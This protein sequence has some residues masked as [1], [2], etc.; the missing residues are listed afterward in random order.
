MN[1]EI[2]AVGTEI[3]LGQ[4]VNT[5]AQIISQ[6]LCELGINVYYQTVVGD[7]PQRLENALQTAKK[8]ANIIITTGG[9]GPTLDDLTKEIIA[10]TFNKKLVLD[11]TSLN[12]IK[13]FFKKINKPM[14]KNNEKQA[15]L[16]EGCTV[17]KNDWGTAPG[18]GFKSEDKYV[19]ML[20][21]PPRECEPMFK[22]CAIPFLY[23][24]AGGFIKSHNVKIFGIG[25]SAMETKLY[26]LMKSMN[27]PTIAPYAK[28]SECFVRITAKADTKEK[29]EEISSPVLKKVVDI[30]GNDVYGIDVNSLEEVVFNLLKKNNMTISVAESCTGGLLSK[31]LTDISGISS[32]YKGGIC[33]YSNEVKINLL[34]VCE[35]TLKEHGAVS[36]QTAKQMAKGISNTLNT[37]IGI[38]ITGIAGPSGDE[39]KPIGLVYISIFM[40][41]KYINKKTTNTGGRDRI[42]YS[43]A[44]TALDMLRRELEKY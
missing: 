19:L 26:D 8:R 21:G 41:G 16:P 35:K 44:S 18:C 20:P 22:N 34:N 9:L 24:L 37:D 6:G 17:F 5:D 42:R 36:E 2:I 29:A 28:Q 3:L 14:T 38:G 27:N 31:R 1:A 33:A 15:Y 11:L 40:N 39:N 30:I 13:D 43:A 32:F 23:P 25:E 7:N 4:I 10:K 12:I